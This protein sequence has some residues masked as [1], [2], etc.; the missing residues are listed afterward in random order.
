MKNILLY[1]TKFLS[2]AAIEPGTGGPETGAL[3]TRPPHLLN[4]ADM[5]ESLA[6]WRWVWVGWLPSLDYSSK[7]ISQVLAH[8]VLWI[9]IRIQDF[10]NSVLDLILD[11]K[12]AN[13]QTNKNVYS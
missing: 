11:L 3:T 13:K 1:G 8:A 9:L 10:S 7:V 4:I 12:L 2:R 5:R 6:T